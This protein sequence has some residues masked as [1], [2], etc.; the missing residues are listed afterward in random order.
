[1]PKVY[2]VNR[3]PEVYMDQHATQGSASRYISYRMVICHAI[4]HDFKIKELT[5]SEIKN[6]IEEL[7]N[8]IETERIQNNNFFETYPLPETIHGNMV[9]LVDKTEGC[10][11]LVLHK[12]KNLP[13]VYRIHAFNDAIKNVSSNFDAIFSVIE[14]AENFDNN[15]HEKLKKHFKFYEDP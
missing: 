1:M 4:Y 14:N 5:K 10:Y 13:K 6:N 15:T 3:H 11:P 8:K 12:D 7:L 9:V 2:E